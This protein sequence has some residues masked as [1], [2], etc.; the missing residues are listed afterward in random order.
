MFKTLQEFNNTVVIT[1]YKVVE[2][3]EAIIRDR[4][5]PS[6]ITTLRNYF[7]ILYPNA[8][9]CNCNPRLKISLDRQ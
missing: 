6:S 7:Y 5:I 8:K 4:K 2:N 3:W 1:I 9:G